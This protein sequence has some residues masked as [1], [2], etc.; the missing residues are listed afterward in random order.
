MID[1]GVNDGFTVGSIVLDNTTGNEL[2]REILGL[3]GI[4][5]CAV[6]Q[7][8]V[9]AAKATIDA[10]VPAGTV[11]R[12]E[13]TLNGSITAN[14]SGET[15]LGNLWADA[16]RWFALEGGIADYYDEDDIDNGNDGV[17]VGDDHV[18]AIWNGGNLRDFV[19]TGDVTMKDI[20][21]V[22]PWPNRV[23]VVY[24]TG[25]Q[26]VEM[27]EAATQALPYH[28]PFTPANSSANAAFPHVAGIEY[29]VDTTIPYDTGE[30]YGNF[31][32]RA[33]SLRRVTINSINGQPFDADALYAV[34]TS[35]AIHNGMD[36]NYISRERNLDFSTITSAMVTD[37]V[38][39]YIQQA[40]DGVI[41]EE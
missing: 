8:A 16:L 17:Q 31:W 15:N 4:A 18:V 5:G 13:V 36:S 34:V 37:V 40:L 32:F 20:L 39:L 29:T 38:W 26:L 2:S 24:L 23:A 21:R 41:G 9:D 3:D 11:A 6:T 12:S 25:G 14:R 19:Y 10:E 1:I 22:L 30:A 35:N 27:L 7:A 28:V 33:N